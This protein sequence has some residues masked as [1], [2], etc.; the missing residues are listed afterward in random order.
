MPE[1][2]AFNRMLEFGQSPS[3]KKMVIL[4]IF[5]MQVI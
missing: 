2:Q 1:W 4:L 3:A 5:D